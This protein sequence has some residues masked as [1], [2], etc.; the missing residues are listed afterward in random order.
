MDATVGEWISSNI[1]LGIVMLVAFVAAMGLV[2]YAFYRAIRGRG[3]R[4][5]E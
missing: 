3:E 5:F 1:S 2:G 4:P